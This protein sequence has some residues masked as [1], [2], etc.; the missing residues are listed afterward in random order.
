M[1][2]VEDVKRA[3]KRCL[4][5][6]RFGQL[7]TAV[8]QEK[9]NWYGDNDELVIPTVVKLSQVWN[10]LDQGFPLGELNATI[11][12]N[13]N[14]NGNVKNLMHEVQVFWHERHDDEETLELRVNRLLRATRDYFEENQYLSGEDSQLLGNAPIQLNDDLYSPFVPANIYAGRPFVKSGMLVLYVETYG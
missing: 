4:L 7:L 2:D 9:N 12:R 3:I 8:Y 10:P 6:E 5:S 14:P 1:A 13:R 11:S